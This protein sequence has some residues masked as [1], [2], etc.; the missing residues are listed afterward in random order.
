MSQT[1]IARDRLSAPI[2]A[3]R[4]AG[5]TQVIN[6]AGSSA[7]IANAVS[8]ATTLVRIVATTDCYYSVGQSPTATTSDN[9]LPAGVIEYIRV[10]PNSD[11]IA[12]I[13]STTSGVLYVTEC[14]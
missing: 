13:R 11:K 4:P 8:S 10:N 14:N 6:Y 2:Q 3:A 9:F 5:G 1:E 7:T 12:A